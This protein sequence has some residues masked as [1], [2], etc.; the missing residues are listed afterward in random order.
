M[1]GFFLFINF[2]RAQSGA[3]ISPSLPDA[4]LAKIVA[5][6]TV[7]DLATKANV[8]AKLQQ[9]YG[10]NNVVDQINIGS[11]SAPSN[12]AASVSGLLTP[13][14]KSV[15]K[16]QLVVEGTNIAIHGEV[17]SD[18]TRQAIGTSLAGAVN[19]SYSVKNGLRVSAADQGTIDQLLANRTVEFENASALLTASGKEI[20]DELAETLKT[21][22]T[23]RIDVIG[24]TDNIG[25]AARNLALSRARA[26][27]VKIYL[28]GKGIA[29]ELMTVSGMGADQPLMENSSEEGRRRNRRI[30]FRLSQ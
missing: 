14:L 5:A 30:E 17:A 24:H 15:H 18:A 27:S 25:A 26:D 23:K 19:E 29:P 9:V 8:L 2:A 21:V 12:W 1:L 20:L 7:P 3:T 13:Q 10:Q 4:R 6:G 11:V 16:G 28:V 22:S